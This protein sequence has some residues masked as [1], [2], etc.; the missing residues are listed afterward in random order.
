[1]RVERVEAASDARLEDYRAVRDPELVRRSAR[2]IAE[3]RLVVQTLLTDSPLEAVSVLCDDTALAWLEREIGDDLP[4]DVPVFVAEDGLDVL[5]GWSFHQGCLA[6]GNRPEPLG[7]AEVLA[8]I[9]EPRL[10]VGLDGVSNPDNVGAIFRTAAAFGVDAVLL[11]PECASPLY[12]KAV[13]TSMGNVLRVPFA[14]GPDW[15]AGLEV[16]REREFNLLALTPAVEAM[17]LEQAMAAMWS[18]TPRALLLGAE[19]PGLGATSIELADERVVI[20]MPGGIDS[21]N[22]AAAAAIALYRLA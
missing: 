21:L 2:F 14:H 7:I 5:G 13:R 3:G 22:V 9:E 1:M 11:S 12:R 20:P 18:H 19:G 8:R 16:L 15:R 4:E 10:V 17:A 6:L